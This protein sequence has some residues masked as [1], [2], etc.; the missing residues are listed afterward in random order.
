MHTRRLHSQCNLRDAAGGGRSADNQMAFVQRSR[1]GRPGAGQGWG[2][3]EQ[4]GSCSRGLGV[5]WGVGWAA[6][7][8]E[9]ASEGELEESR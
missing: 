9:Q 2:S 5:S 6:R 4:F 3:A 1:W 8:L 7:T